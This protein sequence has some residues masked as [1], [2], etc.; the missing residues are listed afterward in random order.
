M[1]KRLKAI[2]FYSLFW[3]SFFFV[4][5]LF[6]ILTHYHEA[7]QFSPGTLAATFWHGLKLDIS[8]TGYG[9]LIPILLMIPGI[10]LTGSW[11]KVFMR[12]YTSVIIIIS[13]GII[14]GDTLLY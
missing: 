4:A 10:Y 9:L 6:F 1:K 5:R 3:L 12:W 2:L 11:F 14:V 7:S 13:S 8:A